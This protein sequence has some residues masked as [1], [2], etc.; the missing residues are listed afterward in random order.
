[1]CPPAPFLPL[2]SFFN[3]QCLYLLIAPILFLFPSSRK[4]KIHSF[5]LL[6][7]TFFTCFLSSFSSSLATSVSLSLPSFGTKVN[8]Q[9]F[10]CTDRWEGERGG[11]RKNEC[12]KASP[13]VLRVEEEELV[14]FPSLYYW[15][16]DACGGDLIPASSVVQSR[17]NHSAEKRKKAFS[18]LLFFS[19]PTPFFLLLISLSLSS[20]PES[21]GSFTIVLCHP[22]QKR[23]AEK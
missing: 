14:A 1:M 8:K 5:F 21:F 10:V 16:V 22:R 6:S 20:S 23:P 11:R 15:V 7:L 12:N 3:L 4:R 2:L 9:T 19:L 13:E 18:S 17:E